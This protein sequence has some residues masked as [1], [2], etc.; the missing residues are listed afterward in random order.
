MKD[1]RGKE[2]LFAVN[3]F[4]ACRK[5]YKEREGLNVHQRPQDSLSSPQVVPLKTSTFKG[6]LV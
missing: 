4:T 6:N 1:E 5:Y 3:L 2:P